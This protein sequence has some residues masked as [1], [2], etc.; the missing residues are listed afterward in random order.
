MWQ[1]YKTETQENIQRHPSRMI[2]GRELEGETDG[3]GE[4]GCQSSGY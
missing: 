3:G 4:G 1:I 2:Q